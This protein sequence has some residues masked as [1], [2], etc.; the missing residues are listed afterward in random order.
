MAQVVVESRAGLVQQVSMRGKQLIADEPVESGGLNSGPTPY[1]LLLAALGTCTA[2]TITLY[3]RRKGWPV[4]SVRVELSHERVH[5][6]DCENCDD[7]DVYLDRFTKV[8]T[9]RGPLDEAKRARLEEISRK[10]PVHRTLLGKIHID[11]ELRLADA[12]P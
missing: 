4:E 3:A 2:M 5:A 7:E 10:C 8:I 9:V 1:E 6:E 11:D 12:A